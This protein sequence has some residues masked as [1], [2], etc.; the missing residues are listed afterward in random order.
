MESDVKEASF[1]L[2][3]KETTIYPPYRE[4]CHVVPTVMSVNALQDRLLIG[5]SHMLKL[6]KVTDDLQLSLL[7]K[8][9][10]HKFH[11]LA[12]STIKDVAWNPRTLE[13]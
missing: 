12:R 6:Y 2:P 8:N 1:F 13:H 9:L 5:G 3:I 7:E 11:P 10:A 4:N